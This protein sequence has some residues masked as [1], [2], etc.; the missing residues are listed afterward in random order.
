MKI[1]VIGGTGFVGSFVVRAF[2]KS[3]HDVTVY[4]RGSANSLPEGVRRIVGARDSLRE[5]TS[6]L[7]R[8]APDVVVDTILSSARQAAELMEVFQ[9][10]AGRVIVLSSQ[11]VY[12]A[13]GI[14]VG[15]EQIPLQAVPITEESA[16]RTRLR[17]YSR[18]QTTRMRD[19]FPW[20]DDEYEKIEVERIVTGDESLPATIVRLPMVY[21]PGDPLHRF[22]PIV[23]RVDDKRPAIFLPRNA[24]DW[25]PSRGYVENVAAAIALATTSERATSQ[26]YNIAELTAYSELEWTR[27]IASSASWDGEVITLEPQATPAHLRV[28]FNTDQDLVAS[29]K[30]IRSELG[31]KEPVPIGEGIRRTIEWERANPP[32]QIDSDP[33]DYAAEDAARLVF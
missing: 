26:V 15:L 22:Y 28:L 5:K 31:F 4:N 1:L 10:A 21:G 29:T 14:L 25:R 13:Y 12:R 19:V 23:K 30:R 9:G 2:L 7:R 18:E 6:E 33:F 8:L 3:D 11:D 16:L 20:L 32:K 17:P 27:L 24:A